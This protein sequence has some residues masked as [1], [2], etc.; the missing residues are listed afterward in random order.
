MSNLTEGTKYD[1]E[2]IRFDLFSPSFAQDVSVVL[3]KGAEKYEA[4]N[5]E[6][7]ILYSRVYAALQRHLNAWWQGEDNDPEW[8]LHHLAHAGC[9]LMFLHWYDTRY[10]HYSEFDDRTFTK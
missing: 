5:W 10:P 2:K 1:E 8:G 3:T 4:H 7:G 6:K 9:C